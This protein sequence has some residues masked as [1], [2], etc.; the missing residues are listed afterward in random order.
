MSKR[1]EL[2]QFGWHG[3]FDEGT[4][5]E[6]VYEYVNDRTQPKESDDESKS[7]S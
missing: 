5:R 7:T 4:M 2:A 3:V 6:A 1:D